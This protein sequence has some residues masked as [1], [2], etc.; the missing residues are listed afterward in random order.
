MDYPSVKN[1]AL[2]LL[3]RREH[4]EY[5]LRTKLKQKFPVDEELLNTLV[6]ELVGL[7]YLSDERFAEMYVRVRQSKGFGRERVM[8]DLQE[9]GISSELASN[10]IEQIDTWLETATHV[11]QKKFCVPA[12]DYKSRMKQMQFLRYRGFTHQEAER[13][14]AGCTFE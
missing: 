1:A 5:E 14:V 10:C 4:S 8:R 3:A 7:N 9:K 6:A 12:E 13:V 2:G 11:W